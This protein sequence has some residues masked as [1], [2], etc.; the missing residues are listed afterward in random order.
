MAAAAV[1]VVE[2]A[3]R[4]HDALARRALPAPGRTELG[5]RERLVRVQLG[6]QPALSIPAGAAVYKETQVSVFVIANGVAHAR[7]IQAGVRFGDRLEVRSG[8]NAGEWVAVQ[9]AGFLSDG[10]HVRVANGRP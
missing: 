6:E 2:P 8:L 4:E 1:G 7:A 9:G 3:L 10:D 5:D